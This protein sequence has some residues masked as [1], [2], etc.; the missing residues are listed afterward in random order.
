MTVPET[1]M[2]ASARRR[3]FLAR[4]DALIFL[5]CGLLWV[6]C[7]VYLALVIARL[8]LGQLEIPP[9][10]WAASWACAYIVLCLTPVSTFLVGARSSR[11]LRS[12]Y[13]TTDANK[14]PAMIGVLVSAA[15]MLLAIDYD[16][17]VGLLGVEGCQRERIGSIVRDVGLMGG[18]ATCCFVTLPTMILRQWRMKMK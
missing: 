13:D 11:S 2:P 3:L 7:A 15:F 8:A 1:E 16:K 17:V 5:H 4:F 14:D 10:L 6:L 12:P 9:A 18:I